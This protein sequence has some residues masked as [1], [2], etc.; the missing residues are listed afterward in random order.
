MGKIRSGHLDPKTGKLPQEDP[1]E[2]WESMAK[3]MPK[4]WFER[5]HRQC[6]FGAPL[7]FLGFILF[8]VCVVSMQLLPPASRWNPNDIQSIELYMSI[9]QLVFAIPAFAFLMTTLFVMPF[10]GLKLREEI[11]SWAAGNTYRE[12]FPPPGEDL[13]KMRMISEKRAKYLAFNER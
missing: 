5:F 1:P 7:G 8:V 13:S 9:G 4:T 11:A 10:H 3:T 2:D 12:R 6:A